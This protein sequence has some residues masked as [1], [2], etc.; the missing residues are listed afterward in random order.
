MDGVSRRILIGV[1]APSRAER[2]ALSD[3]L[4][5]AVRGPAAGIQAA[6][7]WSAHTE[8]LLL[9]VGAE[10]ERWGPLLPALPFDE[11]ERLERECKHLRGLHRQLSSLR[12]HHSRQL[13]SAAP[14][15]S[16]WRDWLGLILDPPDAA[17]SCERAAQL[18]ALE[19][20]YQRSGP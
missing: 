17:P 9:R 5:G 7:H 16:V 13:L 19:Q 1:N 6:L 11:R 4:S 14:G 3:A 15:S 8:A 2:R 18:Q 10:L 12:V 20:R